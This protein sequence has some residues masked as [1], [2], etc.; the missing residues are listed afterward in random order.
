MVLLFLSSLLPIHCLLTDF[1]L[2]SSQ[3]PALTYNTQ[4][5]GNSNATLCRVVYIM[6]LHFNII[7]TNSNSLVV[8]LGE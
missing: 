8:Q 3:P 5:P 2:T 7:N 1:L 4:R 6:Q